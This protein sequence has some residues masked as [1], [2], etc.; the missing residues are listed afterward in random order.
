EHA[1]LAPQRAALY[2]VR[3]HRPPPFRDEKILS[4]WNGLAI[5]AF[6]GGGRMLDEPRYVEAAARAAAHLL[7]TMRP[8][9]RL[10]RSAK[11]GRV[12]AA[13]FLDAYGSAGAGLMDLL[14]AT[15]EPRWL[16]EAI[17]LAGEVERL[18]ADPAGG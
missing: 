8:G 15:F 16:R 4:A 11:D 18:F 7:D 12:G 5:S 3:L 9:G 17:A 10:A 13:G 2:A 14:E 1:A 6:A